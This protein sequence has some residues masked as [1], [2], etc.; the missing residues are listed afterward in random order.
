MTAAEFDLILSGQIHCALCGE[1]VPLQDTE[2]VLV[3]RVMA[4]DFA[5]DRVERA[6][7]GC[8]AVFGPDTGRRTT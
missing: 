1:L 4:W 5:V 7:P 2:E 3:P 8:A 6:C